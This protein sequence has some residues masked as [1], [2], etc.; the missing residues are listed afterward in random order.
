MKKLCSF[1]LALLLLTST[2]GAVDLYVDTAKVEADTPPTVVD[3][4]TLVPVRAIFEAIGATVTWDAATNTATGVR[5]DVVVSIQID[6]ITAYVNGEPRTLDVPA[7][8]IN[9]RT[10]VPARFISES[11][12]CD[13]TWDG[14]TGTAAV[15]YQLKGRKLY[16]TPTGERYHYDGS[17]NGGTYYE[18][19]LAEINGR[20]LTPCD[21]CV[22]TSSS[23]TPSALPNI[24][25]EPAGN[26]TTTVLRVVDGDTFVVNYN[27][28]E[29]YV[30]LIGV[31]TPESVHP[32]NTK[33]TDAGFAASEFTK[34]YLTGKEIE[35]EFDVQQRDQYG[36]LLAYAYFDGEM[37]NEK[38]LR[39][40]YAN[41]ATYP[42]NVKYVNRF[43][44]IMSSRDSSIPSGE[45]C[46]GYMKA[47]E[48]IYTNPGGVS[49]LKD[50]FLY[51]DGIIS[52]I[53]T[54][55][56][57]DY[58]V[59][60][61]QN[62]NVYI[63]SFSANVFASLRVGD[64]ARI[65]FVYLGNT[66]SNSVAATYLEVLLQNPQNSDTP[67]ADPSNTGTTGSSPSNNSYQGTVYVS[68]R[69]N[70]I[71]SVPDCGGMKNYREMSREEADSRGY[72]YCPNCW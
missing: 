8:L 61:A 57:S 35:L 17:C 49:G 42:P 65:G 11:M 51:E 14:N 59:L 38:L 29:E 23:T 71:H 62:G 1:L 15:A 2:A 69:S 40:G 33:N 25:T 58:M 70:T 39:T 18:T 64:S 46:D 12:G 31:D 67:I 41:M 24:S 44:E 55:K 10:M 34:A 54:Y 22:L 68:S 6:N 37:F 7:Q 50:A 56:N 20:H 27:G 45:Y 43:T 4:R 13:V 5:G 60:S 48:I 66:S 28:V 53:G 52:D 26:Y 9:G 36:R 47:P 19:S 21:K 30:R 72:K 32:D 3:G 63:I 16:A